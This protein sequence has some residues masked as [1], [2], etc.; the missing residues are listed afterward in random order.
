MNVITSVIA[1]VIA[2]V[3]T[4]VLTIGIGLALCQ[5]VQA[6]DAAQTDLAL[7]DA[8]MLDQA[9]QAELLERAQN[10]VGLLAPLLEQEANLEQKIAEAINAEGVALEESDPEQLQR[11]RQELA[12][13]QQQITL[14]LTGVSELDYRS[15]D[16]GEFDINNEIEQLIEPFVLV[17]N[18]ATAEARLLERTRRELDIAARRQAEAE[19][20]ILNLN[21]LI[22][23][24][25][26]PVIAIRLDEALALWRERL[27]VQQTQVSAL[28]L[29][30]EDLQN[31]NAA[32]S[33]NVNSAF[34]LFFRDRGISL[35]LG[36]GAFLIVLTVLR[37]VVLLLVRIATAG[38]R[39]KNFFVRLI[40]LILIMFSVLAGYAAMLVVFNLRN[41][42]LLLGLATLVLFAAIWLVIKM[43]PNLL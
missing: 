31:Q 1:S 17:L 34:Q 28:E 9:A 26:S 40:N 24:N 35:V 14:L 6:Q 22:E 12:D 15:L 4:R 16:E 37:V 11:L 30:V 36:L 13:N 8:T 5:P 39:K 21:A 25:A 27:A 41:D 38:R 32:V 3:S 2:R 23:F 10:T 7:Q 18:E 20:A 42:W 43:L 19:L 33:F 29:R